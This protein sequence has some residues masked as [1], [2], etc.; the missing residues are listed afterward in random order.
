MHPR[1]RSAFR[2]GGALARSRRTLDRARHSVRSAPGPDPTENGGPHFPLPLGFRGC[3]RPGLAGA[4]QWRSARSIHSDQ[5]LSQVFQSRLPESGPY[6]RQVGYLTWP[7]PVARRFPLGPRGG[8]PTPH[9]SRQ[10]PVDGSMEAIRRDGPDRRSEG[11]DPF[12][13][14]SRLGGLSLRNAP[15]DALRAS[16]GTEQRPSQVAATGQPSPLA[17]ITRVL[18]EW[19]Q[20]YRPRA[21]WMVQR[22]RRFRIPVDLG[23]QPVERHSMALLGGRRGQGCLSR[24]GRGLFSLLR[25]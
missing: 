13:H 17:R 14:G 5:T 3:L 11:F 2:S 1:R 9:R 10:Q 21:W 6:P 23:A 16:P 24:T 4:Q 7:L 25:P 20:V 22:Q 8:S 12:R 19:N 18:A 15:L